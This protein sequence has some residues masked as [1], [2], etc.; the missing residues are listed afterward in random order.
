MNTVAVQPIRLTVVTKGLHKT[1]SQGQYIQ[2]CVEP[3]V[4]AS[5]S[6]TSKVKDAVHERN[7]L[8]LLESQQRLGP[9]DDP[10]VLNN[11]EF[12]L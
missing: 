2:V 5:Y 7:G 9:W 11:K 3:V 8:T 4:S 1:S 10:Q 12:T 6:N